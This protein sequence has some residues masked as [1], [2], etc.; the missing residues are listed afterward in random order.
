M[1]SLFKGKVVLVTGAGRGIGF[2]V[3]KLFASKG[4]KVVVNDIPRTIPPNS[5]SPIP[6]GNAVLA[7][8][9]INTAG[10]NAR[11]IECDVSDFDAT[12]QMVERIID[13]MGGI[14]VLINNAAFLTLGLSW[15]ITETQW[16]EGINVCLKGTWNC[17]RHVLEPMKNNGWGCIVNCSSISALGTAGA[18]VYGTA[19]AGV[20]GLTNCV[21]ID[22]REHNV[23]CNAV[24]PQAHQTIAEREAEDQELFRSR[25]ELG[26]ISLQD[27]EYVRKR[28]HP[29]A[30]APFI[31]YLATDAGHEINGGLFFVR[32]GKVAA[33]PKPI[34][35]RQ[36][37]KKIENPDDGIWTLDELI[38][39][40]H[41]LQ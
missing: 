5:N 35:N 3:A 37:V 11:A 19:K 36:I 4:A 39:R 32:G 10:G 25:L 30:V 22:M 38:A 29:K 8:E 6:G 33:Y 23:T 9:K 16:D 7:A 26:Q 1:T 40:G 24:F 21:A 41:E 2:E 12:K 18:P 14:H 28:P 15:E 17:T 27:Y 13:E 31:C 34:P 20:V